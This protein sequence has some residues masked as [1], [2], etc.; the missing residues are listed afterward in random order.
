MLL[1]ERK[2]GLD[3]KTIK[4]QTYL[5]LQKWFTRSVNS[6]F[7]TEFEINPL[8]SDFYRPTSLPSGI[9]WASDLPTPYKFPISSMVGYGYFLEPRNIFWKYVNTEQFTHCVNSSV[10]SLWSSNQANC[11][12]GLNST[13]ILFSTVFGLVY[14]LNWLTVCVKISAKTAESSL[15]NKLYAALGQTLVSSRERSPGTLYFLSTQH[16]GNFSWLIKWN[17]PFRLV[18][19]GQPIFLG[20]GVAAHLGHQAFRLPLH[21]VAS[22]VRVKQL[23]NWTLYPFGKILVTR[24][25][26]TI[27]KSG[28]YST[29]SLIP[30]LWIKT[31]KLANKCYFTHTPPQIPVLPKIEFY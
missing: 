11:L 16:S 1:E 20:E 23:L 3:E 22:H 30:P 26:N 18:W 27:L 17:G 13:R 6:N 15:V 19:T 9:S 14:L 31:S 24:K 21:D 29:F 4:S 28:L 8:E 2:P 10:L 25:M 12:P 7:R 5:C